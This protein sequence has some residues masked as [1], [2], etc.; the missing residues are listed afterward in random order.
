MKNVNVIKLLTTKEVAELLS[1]RFNTLEIWRVQGKGPKFKKI[2]RK[3]LYD[4]QDVFEYL[5]SQTRTSTS[6]KPASF[7]RRA[8]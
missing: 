4:Q 6:Q 5:E 3:V 8:S 1:V 2:G 7:R